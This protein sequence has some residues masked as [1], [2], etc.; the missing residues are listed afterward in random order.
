MAAYTYIARDEHGNK[1]S[2]TYQ[3]VRNVA[4]LRE[5][6]AKIGYRLVKAHRAKRKRLHH[7]RIPETDVVSLTFQ[8]AGMFSAGLSVLQCLET[9]EEQTKNLSLK[10]VVADIRERVE[11]GSS[12]KKAFAK[13][14]DVFGRFFVGMVEAGETGAKL[15]ESLE[16]SA[17]YLEKRLEL[18]SKVRAA[19]LYPAIVAGVSLLVVGG[20]LTFVVP[21][22][23]KLYLRLHV[24]LPA[25]TQFL[26]YL[27]QTIRE[28]WYLV[29]P[30]L[31]LLVFGGKR[32]LTHPRARKV[33]DYLKLNIPI[34]GRLTR[35]VMVSRFIRTFATLTGVG[36]P[37]IEAIDVSRVVANNVYWTRITEQIKDSVRA[38]NPIAQA[39]QQDPIFPSVVVRM[40]DSG[41]QAG[42]LSVMLNKAAEFLDKDIE[43]TV[44]GLLT[45]LE[46]LLTL[47]LGGVIGLMLMGVYLPM[48]DYMNQMK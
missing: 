18:R 23:E 27:S 36:V 16:L 29:L 34:F 41:E 32:L 12:L 31:L 48:I 45:K 37:M 3:N 39:L 47:L 19:F 22:F 15:G 20:L 8:F 17:R 6:L 44:N 28:G 46:P 43:R 14:E 11:T 5:E 7:G 24:T 1:F 25:P 42:I 33:I 30:I 4:M 13:H 35:L 21:M 9:L 10:T 2:G 26:I 38:G 40:A